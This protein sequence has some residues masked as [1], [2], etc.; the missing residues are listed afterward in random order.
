VRTTELIDTAEHGYDAEL[1][2]IV[3]TIRGPGKTNRTP[4]ACDRCGVRPTPAHAR[5]E[6]SAEILEDSTGVFTGY[7]HNLFTWFTL[8]AECDGCGRTP[9]VVD[10]ETA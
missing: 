7:E 8:V 4:Y 3:T 5:F 2:A 1:G 10:F 6:H 9:H